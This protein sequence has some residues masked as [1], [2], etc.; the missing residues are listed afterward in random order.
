M[1]NCST[2][3]RVSC[4]SISHHVPLQYR[5]TTFHYSLSISSRPFLPFSQS[6]PTLHQTV[7]PSLSFMISVKNGNT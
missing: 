7:P 5:F 4:S 6:Q 1:I 3:S 2:S